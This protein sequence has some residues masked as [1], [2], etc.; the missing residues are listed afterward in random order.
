[1]IS[2]GISTL[3]SLEARGPIHSTSCIFTYPEKIDGAQFKLSLERPE[4]I[5]G[6]DGMEMKINQRSRPR[7]ITSESGTDASELDASKAVNPQPTHHMN[8]FTCGLLT[9]VIL[10]AA[11]WKYHVQILAKAKAEALKAKV[12][13]EADA[14][15]L[16][17]KLAVSLHL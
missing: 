10:T 2:H 8:A 9:G 15:R 16:A 7:F 1:M 13:A 3:K 14:K 4:V 6:G 5:V 12:A 17:D 11:G